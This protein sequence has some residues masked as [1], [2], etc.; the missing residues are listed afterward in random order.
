[1]GGPS[2]LLASASPRRRDLVAR[3]GQ[4]IAHTLA[5][6][7]DETPLPLESPRSYV[8]RMAREKAQA[9]AK[10]APTPHHILSGD[11]VVSVGRRILP[12]AEDSETARACLNLLSG[13][14]HHVLSAIAVLSPDGILREKLCD[15]IVCFKT[16]NTSEI[17]AYIESM[18]W[19]GKAG[20]YAIQG[21]AESYI[22]WIRGSHSAVMGLPLYETRLLLKSFGFPVL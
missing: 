17:D 20:G 21:A 12:K 15:T 8:Q 14:R 9:A 10:M 3:L 6:D 7:I 4:D 1:M 2:L 11:T 22:K 13:R 5:P 18:E 19:Q 16:L